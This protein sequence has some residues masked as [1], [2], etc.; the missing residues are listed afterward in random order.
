MNSAGCYPGL[1][2]SE[3]WEVLGHC[4]PSRPRTR[5]PNPG[6]SDDRQTG[7]ETRP[8]RSPLVA[9][10]KSMPCPLVYG[11]RKD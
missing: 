3:Y 1:M 5:N 11:R 10:P 6:R 4:G 2:P 8:N 9:E 7:P